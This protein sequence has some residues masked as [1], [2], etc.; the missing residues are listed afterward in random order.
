LALCSLVCFIL[1]DGHWADALCCHFQF[2]SRV[3]CSIGLLSLAGLACPSR[4]DI[5]LM[6]SVAF[7]MFKSRL[8]GSLLSYLLSSHCCRLGSCILLH[9]AWALH[10]SWATLPLALTCASFSS[11]GSGLMH[12]VSFFPLESLGCLAAAAKGVLAHLAGSAFSCKPAYCLAWLNFAFPLLSAFLSTVDIGLVH[13]AAFLMASGGESFALSLWCVSF[14]RMG[15]GLM[16]SVAT[17]NSSLGCLAP[18]GCFLLQGL[19]A[20]RE[21]RHWPDALCCIFNVQV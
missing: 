13:Y 19:L 20:P 21:W 10:D 14:S 7:S 1:E 17:F 3:S 5:G 15:T 18:L 12:T 6:H 8:S 4:M 11:M 16:H 2:K 9:F